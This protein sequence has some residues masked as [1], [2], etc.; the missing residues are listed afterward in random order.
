MDDDASIQDL[1]D[2]A[3]RSVD[4]TALDRAIAS[5]D[6]A[7]EAAN[8]DVATASATLDNVK[9]KASDL[10]QERAD[11]SAYRDF[12]VRLRGLPAREQAPTRERRPR[13]A[14]RNA[15]LD[16][17]AD[18]AERHT[19]V[20]RSA[21]MEKGVIGNSDAQAHSLQVTLSRMYRRGEL[22]RPR[23]AVYKL[24][25]SAA[26]EEPASRAGEGVLDV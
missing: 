7:I 10:R 26:A 22:G 2:Q 5:L 13:G 20:I 25:P 11:Y 23:K 6:A 16:F 1:L 8:V 18:G 9:K 12:V 15:I 14:M 24:L 3:P 19:D 17:L 21:L 4:V